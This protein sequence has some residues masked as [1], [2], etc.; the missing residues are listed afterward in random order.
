MTPSEDNPQ[1]NKWLVAMTVMLPTFIEIMDTSV[2]NVSLPHIQGSLSAGLDEVTWVLTSYLV[3][4]AIVIPITGWLAGMFGRK[5]YLLFSLSMFT[6]SSLI[7]GAAPSLEVLVVA[8]VFQGIGGGGLQP[9]SQAI[10]LESFPTKE[11][12]LAMAVFGMGIVMAPIMGPVLGGWVTDTLTWRWI[13]YIN[14]PAGIVA[15]TLVALF[16]HD[17]SYVKRARLKID[18]WG[19]FLLTVGLGCLQI[20]LDKGQREDWF[21]SNFILIMT[22]GA[23]VAL[24][25]FVMVEWNTKN[26]VVDLRVF[27][28]RSFTAGN[29]IMFGGF[30]CLFGSIFLLPLYLQ[31]LMDYTAFWAGLVLGPGG[32]A[33][34]F[35]MPVAGLLMKK[36]VSPRFLL[37]IGVTLG[38]YSLWLMSGFNLFAGFMAV[39]YP[40]MVQ[41]LAMGLFF[42]PLSTAA[43][44]TIPKEEIGN[45]SGIF[46]LLRN[47]GGSVGVAFST[48]LLARRTQVHQSFLVEHITPYN[49]AFQTYYT[50]VEQWLRTQHPQLKSGPAALAATYN[51]LLRQATMM[52][53][54]D[55]FW[56]LALALACL[57]PVTLVFR[58]G[59]GG[60]ALGGVH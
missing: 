26:P 12:G 14:L 48:T 51:E 37:A 20:V 47:L 38:A 59:K 18:T 5:R 7:C 4:N 33:S 23:A 13:F 10:L 42:V 57:I 1:V 53:F 40:R 52:A 45:A 8:R 31:K 22:A 2:V 50:Q 35:V 60:G 24:I 25:L 54:N 21:N 16:I 19:L 28:D 6:I 58:G 41:G 34:F 29:V 3:S 46:N 32:L 27:R 11:R 9:L 56:F 15:V 43:F 17:P 44:A 49:P 36:D 30:F 55:T 39:S